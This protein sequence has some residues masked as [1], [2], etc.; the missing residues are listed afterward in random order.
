MKP[1]DAIKRRC[2][3]SPLRFQLRNIN[4]HSALLAFPVP[5]L[6]NNVQPPLVVDSI[7][8]VGVCIPCGDRR[9]NF[10]DK[11]RKLGKAMAMLKRVVTSR[12]NKVNLR[13]AVV[14]CSENYSSVPRISS[15]EQR[16]QRAE[17]MLGCVPERDDVCNVIGVLRMFSECDI[18]SHGLI[19]RHVLPS[20]VTSAAD[21]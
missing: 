10:S 18:H 20:N 9:P 4:K 11:F 7:N 15:N 19:R 17:S 13:T 8:P 21:K 6:S 12:F 16:K 14:Q 3:F 2:A 5:S 1:N